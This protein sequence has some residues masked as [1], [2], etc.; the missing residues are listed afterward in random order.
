[1][2]SVSDVGSAADVGSA[3]DDGS[4]ADVGSA[5]DVDVSPAQLFV[6]ETTTPSIVATTISPTCLRLIR[7]GEL[8]ERVGEAGTVPW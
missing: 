3:V 7:R 8:G 4:T 5:S 6:H 2:C 1:M